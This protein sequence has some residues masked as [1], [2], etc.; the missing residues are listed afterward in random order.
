MLS[1]NLKEDLK[2]PWLR[3]ILAIIGT[4]VVVNVAF[5]TYAFIYPPNLVVKDYYERGKEYFHDQKLRQDALPT[6]WR[7]QLLLPNTLN[8]STPEI[9][10]LY[11]MN[12]QGKPVQSG[13][14]VVSAYHI[15]DSSHDFKLKL[16]PVDIGTFAA[17]IQFPIP[18]KWDLIANIDAGEK[19]FDTVTHIFVEK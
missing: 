4:T 17:P 19:H 16:K 12:H 5:I 2:N 13:D 3:V 7:L 15:S 10:R 14:V 18:G 9:C 8:I 1:D 11:V 6:A